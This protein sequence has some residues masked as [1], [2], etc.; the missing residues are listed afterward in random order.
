ME[1]NSS[2]PTPAHSSGRGRDSLEC[3][4]DLLN[5]ETHLHVACS[6]PSISAKVVR[7]IANSCPESVKMECMHDGCLPLHTLC[8]NSKL[9]EQ[10]S[11]EILKI[12]VSA[13]PDSL[14]KQVGTSLSH[15]GS[16]SDVG[17]LPIRL[18][19]EYMSIGFCKAFL[20]ERAKISSSMIDAT[21]LQMAC[22]C[23]CSLEMI[24]KLVKDDPALLVKR[25]GNGH[26]ALHTAAKH[27]SLEVVSYLVDGDESTVSALDE[28]GE[29]PLHKA[30]R[31]GKLDNAQ[32]LMTKNTS[33]ITTRSKDGST[34]LHLAAKIG[35]FELVKHIVEVDESTLAIPDEMGELPLHNACRAGRTKCAVFMMSKNTASLTTRNCHGKT[36]LHLAASRPWL[37]IVKC[38]VE[39]NQSILALSDENRESIL[40]LS[41]ENGERPLHR[42]C[43]AG[44]IKT[45][46]YLMENDMASVANKN[47]DGQLPIFILSNKSGKSEDLL[48]SVEYTGTIFKMLQA[49]PQTVVDGI[50]ASRIDL[51][52]KWLKKNNF[53]CS[54]TLL[55]ELLAHPEIR[56]ICD[57]VRG[58]TG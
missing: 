42:A 51:S 50:E 41:D 13:F 44:E 2:T 53:E 31:A 26:I 37:G 40:A 49:H 32:Y 58:P 21:I 33:S 3:G 38:L 27:A 8:K 45:V 29:L 57:S 46:E 6:N 18:A 7:I 28:L 22:V 55:N 48:Q 4:N 20:S 35:S 9:G 25:D 36:A 12:L 5:S 23:T 19:E 54:E 11:I 34:A 17:K 43:G 24:K 14:R 30:C 15:G 39:L 16:P 10:S 52:K 1:F 47:L 56:K